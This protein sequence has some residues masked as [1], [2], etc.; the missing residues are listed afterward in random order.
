MNT[1]AEKRV[2]TL[3]IATTNKG[4]VSEIRSLL[5]EL[6]C[7]VISLL[8][9]PHPPP[10]VEETGKTFAEN[11]LI[12]AE[13]YHAH[14]GLLTIADDSGLEV[15]ALG[16]RPGVYSARYGGPG[17]TSADQINLLLEE[18]KDVPEEK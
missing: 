12:K 10:T 8:D 7:H 9:L 13:Y 11:A 1:N 17:R 6:N 3:L 5:Q 2:R 4:K 18:M 16:G 14:S 15:D